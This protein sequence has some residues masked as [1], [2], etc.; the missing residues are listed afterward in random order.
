MQAT[1]GMDASEARHAVPRLLPA[2]AVRAAEA[3]PRRGG[4]EPRERR[5]VIKSIPTGTYI[6]L[7]RRNSGR[8]VRGGPEEHPRLEAESERKRGDGTDPDDRG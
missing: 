1:T 8:A 3:V 6:K 2:G 5:W 4:E 7:T